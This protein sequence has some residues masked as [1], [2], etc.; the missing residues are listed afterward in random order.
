VVLLL[1]MGVSGVTGL[2]VPE[3]CAAVEST[4]DDGT[5]PPT[6]VTCGCCHHAVDVA[7]TMPGLVSPTPPADSTE[8]MRSLSDRDPRDILHVPRRAA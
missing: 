2:V 4:G 1:A 8:P 6:C 5:C 7:S 3:P